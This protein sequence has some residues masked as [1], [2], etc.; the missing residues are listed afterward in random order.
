M[1]HF[2][3]LYSNSLYCKQQS[4]NKKRHCLSSGVIAFVE[5]RGIGIQ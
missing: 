4:N 2:A 1:T 5:S 3:L